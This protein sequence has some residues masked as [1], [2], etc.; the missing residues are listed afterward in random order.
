MAISQLANYLLAARRLHFVG[1]TA[2]LTFFQSLLLSARLPVHVLHIVG[3]GGIGKTA[4]LAGF[5]ALCDQAQIPVALL[6]AHNIEPSPTSFLEALRLALEAPLSDFPL[7]ALISRSQRQVILIDTYEMLAPLDGWLREVLLPQLSENTLVVLAGRYPLAP[8][9]RSDPGWQSLI[10]VL[11]LRNLSPEESRIYLRSRGVPGE[12]HENILAFTHGHPLALSLVADIFAQRHDARFEPENE[13]DVVKMLLER[14]VQKVPGPAHRAALEVCALVRLTTEGL[15]ASV[16]AMPDVH[17]LFEWLRG[18][19]FIESG[20]QGL[21]PHDLAREALMADLRWRNPDWYAELQRR[22]R[23][24]YIARFQQRQGQEQQDILLDYIYLHRDNLALRSYFQAFSWQES[25]NLLADVMRDADVPVLLEMVA[26][27]EGEASAHLARHWL[28]CQP[29]GVIV[30][31]DDTWQPVGFLA[32]VALHEASPGELHADPATRSVWRYM[33][34]QGALRPGERAVIFRFWMARDTYQAFSPVQTLIG[35]QIIRYS[36]FTPALA[37]TFFPCANPEFWGPVLAHAGQQRILEADF[38]VDR[39][40][41][42]VYGH[43][44][45]ATPPLMWL[46]KREIATTS[47]ALVPAMAPI[48]PLAALSEAEFTAAVRDALRNFTRPDRLHNNPLLRSRLVIEQA[49]ISTGVGERVAMLRRLLKEA[50]QSLQ[51]SPRDI[52]LYR[53]LYHTYLHPAATQERV[54]AMLDLPFSTYRRYLQ[55]AIR[56]VAAL[57]WQRELPGAHIR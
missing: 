51:A 23:A 21:V 26:R 22:A 33:Q 9:W 8:A 1:R 54:A 43:N 14:L 39:R 40:R 24:Y 11:P 29:Q 6:D 25:G 7:H 13:P 4:L 15:L 50:A 38:I 32:T 45:R 36:L 37:F 2:E 53:T 48:E 41:Y 57:L 12:Q 31:R 16:L 10:R 18:L 30:I 44:W 34:A 47:P 49:G 55:T 28:T 27:H 19:S 17:D 46:A 35:T 5:V 56:R 42:S 52:R 3:P 20:R